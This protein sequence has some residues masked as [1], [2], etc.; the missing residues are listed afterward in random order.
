MFVTT[1][2]RGGGGGGGPGEL[3]SHCEKAE[4][5]NEH[6]LTG[7]VPEPTHDVW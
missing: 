1:M 7:L 6:I 4:K 2:A 3:E 5:K